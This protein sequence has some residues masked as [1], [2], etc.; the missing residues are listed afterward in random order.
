MARMFSNP[1]VEWPRVFEVLARHT[2]YEARLDALLDLVAAATRHPVVALY[3]ADDPEGRFFLAR[4]R[5]PVPEERTASQHADGGV[6]FLGGSLGDLARE[7][8]A[9]EAIEATEELYPDSVSAV[10][11]GLPLDLPRTPELASAG[12]TSTPLGVLYSVPLH[13]A[14]VQIGLVQV[15]P[16]GEKPGRGLR[17]VMETAAEPLAHAVA[18]AREQARLQEQLAEDEARSDVSRQM[19]RSAFE[20]DEFLRLLLDL[21]V[22]ASGTQAGFIGLADESGVIHLHTAVDLP[23]G[24]LDHVELTPGAGFLE[25][26]DREEGSLYLA[27][28]EQAA[29][30]GIRAL[31]AVPLTDAERVLGVLGLLNLDAGTTPA[32]HSLNLLAIFAEQIQLV[33]GNVR[34]FEAFNRQFVGTLH[35]LARA[36]DARYPHTA[37]H[38][39]RVTDWALAIGREMALS[40][41]Q[42]Q[43][44]R[45][46]ALAHD[47]GMCGI[48]EVEHGF[49]ADFHH[50]SIGASMFELLPQGRAVGEIVAS[51]HEWYDGWGFPQGL[52]GE[53]IPPG[54][55]ILALAEFVVEST[56]AD[57]IQ[58]AMPPSKLM[59]EVQ[60]RR[61]RQFDPAV[62]DAWMAIFERG[63]RSAP[64]GSPF[65]PCHLFKGDPALACSTCPARGTSLP[66][67]TIPEVRCHHHGDP[68]CARC[69]VYL[70]AEERAAAAGQSVPPPATRQSARQ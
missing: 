6:A 15:G 22:K 29:A 27:D 43:A 47:V 62:V 7:E 1:S 67:W 10:A 25:W 42:L 61:G 13:R 9:L 52:K 26:L 48:V 11:A 54:A 53:E 12:A 46:A 5:R 21:A 37:A 2:G 45:E 19:L 63:R 20:P 34:L 24:L 36:L 4:L 55:R 51:H 3:L 30:L 40:E 50:P 38:H 64:A 32:E 44:L 17:K 14:D 68:D 65:Q 39:R 23:E 60:I 59:A 18:L 56:T 35:A 41:A 16:I 70:E 57:P 66:C 8:Q 28:F 69:F 58:G 31:L 49:Q 33:L